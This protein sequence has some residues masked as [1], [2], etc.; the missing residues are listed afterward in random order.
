MNTM[1][2]PLLLYAGL[3]GAATPRAP[4]ERVFFDG[5]I[6]TAEPAH[7]YAEAVAI[8]GDKIVAVGSRAEVARVVGGGGELI[9]LKGRFLMPGLIDS[10]CHAID[11]GLSLISADFAQ[12]SVSLDDLAAFAA[13][14]KRSG[15]GMQGDILVVGGIPLEFW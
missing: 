9:D 1:F 11:G 13:A 6:F 3:Q 2:I 5:K 15:R 12:R 10:H 14:A 8:R 4:D 7:P